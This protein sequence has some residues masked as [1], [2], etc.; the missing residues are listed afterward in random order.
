MTQE[1]KESQQSQIE[2]LTELAVEQDLLLRECRKALEELITKKPML[3]SL[4]CG[5]TTLGNLRAMLYE[6]KD[7]PRLAQAAGQG[8]S[9]R[10]M[11]K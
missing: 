6:Y 9:D 10:A 11:S 5:N 7:L 4:L 8:Q 1:T 2:K 3:T